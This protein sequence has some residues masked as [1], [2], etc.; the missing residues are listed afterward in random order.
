MKNSA[1]SITTTVASVQLEEE[2]Q[3]ELSEEIPED[4]AELVKANIFYEKELKKN[5]ESS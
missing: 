3:E 1:K 4:A 5:H 2:L